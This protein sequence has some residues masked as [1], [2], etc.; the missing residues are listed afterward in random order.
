MAKCE[1][2][3]NDYD[4]TFTVTAGGR[5]Q[6]FDTIEC[7]IHAMAPECPHCGCKV[8]GHGVEKDGAVYCCV[9]CARHEG[10]T[11]LKDRA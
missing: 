6:T 4:N 10:V 7:A 2:C 1:V 3:G 8:V 11:G 9:H 5:S